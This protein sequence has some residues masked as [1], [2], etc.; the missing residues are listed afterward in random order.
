MEPKPIILVRYS[1]LGSSS[2][3]FACKFA[4]PFSQG[5]KGP[6]KVF[7]SCIIVCLKPFQSLALVFEGYNLPE[8]LQCC[9][10]CEAAT[11]FYSS[12]E[13]VPNHQAR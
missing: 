1:A 8:V 10:S 2:L 9:T 13:L 4:M 6:V 12:S 7:L 3:N 5:A 11:R